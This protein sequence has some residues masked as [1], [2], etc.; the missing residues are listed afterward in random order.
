MSVKVK[1]KLLQR[2]RGHSEVTA[3]SAICITS[4]INNK[5]KLFVIVLV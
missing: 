4:L 1:V 3:L 2:D 5:Y